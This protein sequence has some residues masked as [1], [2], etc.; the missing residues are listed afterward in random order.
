MSD[1]A[2]YSTFK[3]TLIIDINFFSKRR[4]CFDII[5]N[6][7]FVLLTEL[8][9]SQAFLKT[10]IIKVNVNT[11]YEILFSVTCSQKKIHLHIFQKS[12]TAFWFVKINRK[13]F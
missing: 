10:K 12:D 7:T 13:K 9:R 2:I 1:I 6:L 5:T 11:V 4:S 8:L 3:S